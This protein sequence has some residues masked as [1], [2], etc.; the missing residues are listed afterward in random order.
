[1]KRDIFERNFSCID[2]KIFKDEIT[3]APNAIWWE[4]EKRNPKVDKS[5]QVMWRNTC[6]RKFAHNILWNFQLFK[7]FSKQKYHFIMLNK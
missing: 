2:F 6:G 3:K 5:K 1:M 4:A 7:F